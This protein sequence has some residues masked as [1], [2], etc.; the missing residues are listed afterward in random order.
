MIR[1]ISSTSWMCSSTATPVDGQSLAPSREVPFRQP[2]PIAASGILKY[3]EIYIDEFGV[4]IEV[5]YFRHPDGTVG[6]VK[7]RPRS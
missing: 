3:Y 2:R 1:W 6:D 4:E 7:I 5:H